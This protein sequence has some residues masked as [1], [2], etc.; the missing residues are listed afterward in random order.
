M[1]LRI[2]SKICPRSLFSLTPYVIDSSNE[3]GYE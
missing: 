3:I 1:T 2:S